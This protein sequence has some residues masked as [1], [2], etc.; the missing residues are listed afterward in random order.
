MIGTNDVWR[1]FDLPLEPYGVDLATYEQK[2]EEMITRTLPYVKGMVIMTPYYLEPN[3]ADA[4]R[5]RMDEYG[6]VCKALADKY[7]LPFVDTQAAFAPMLENMHSAAIQ[8][9]RVHPNA[10]GHMLLASALLK[11]LKFEIK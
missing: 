10:P 1:Q 9:D 5:A 3:T 8:W 2:L 7:G 4:M 11:A 6:A